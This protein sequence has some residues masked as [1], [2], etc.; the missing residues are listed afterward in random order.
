MKRLML[1]SVVCAFMAAP[2]LADMAYNFTYYHDSGTLYGIPDI[3]NT[4]GGG[5]V[6]EYTIGS[7][8]RTM[9]DIAYDWDNNQLYGVYGG[10]Y[11]ISRATGKATLVASGP[12]TNALGWNQATGG[13][14]AASNGSGNFYD[15]T[16]AGVY[17]FI[18]KYSDGVST[19]SSQGDIWVAAD[20][21]VYATMAGGIATQK[22]WLAT[23]NPATAGVTLIAPIPDNSSVNDLYGLTENADG[24]LLV[25]QSNGNVYKL[26][27]S[28]LD[29]IGADTAHQ[30]WGATTVPVPGAV[31]LGLLGLS[32]AGIKLRKFT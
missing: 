5:F 19:Y 20:G 26:N 16:A 24:E 10:L 3:T 11:T 32:A 7:F 31:L 4:S 12:T 25:Y 29:D 17:T 8:G 21:T 22:I 27:G 1:I 2:A 18:G 6:G 30:V 13:F 28:N 23:V 9:A 14:Y 15:V